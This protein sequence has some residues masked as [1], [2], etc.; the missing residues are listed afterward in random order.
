[1]TKI[2]YWLKLFERLI[3]YEKSESELYQK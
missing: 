2:V 1:L 3:L